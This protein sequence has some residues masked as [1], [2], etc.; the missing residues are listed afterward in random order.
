MRENFIQCKLS[1]KMF[2]S[3]WWLM[4]SESERERMRTRCTWWERSRKKYFF[5][6]DSFRGKE[7]VVG[8]LY[9]QQA[10]SSWRR[11]KHTRKNSQYDTQFGFRWDETVGEY[12]IASTQPIK[13]QLLSKLVTDE[14]QVKEN[15]ISVSLSF[16]FYSCVRW[17]SKFIEVNFYK[18]LTWRLSVNKREKIF[19][20]ECE[21]ICRESRKKVQP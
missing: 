17:K 5:F 3:L 13:K 1:G 19:G 21:N 6:F 7:M 9:T 10:S 20:K 16:L 15:F 4:N 14:S 11:E 12:N 2:V 18:Y 8:K